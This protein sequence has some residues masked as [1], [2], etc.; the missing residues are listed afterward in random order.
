MNNKNILYCNYVTLE[1][2]RVRQ[3]ES[4]RE[5]LVTLEGNKTFEC[6]FKS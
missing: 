1:S 4:E 5:R 6:F 2:R 3:R